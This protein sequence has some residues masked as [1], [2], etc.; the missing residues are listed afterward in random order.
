VI[1]PFVFR[2]KYV[3]ISIIIV[4][5]LFGEYLTNTLAFEILQRKSE[6]SYQCPGTMWMEVGI[7]ALQVSRLLLC[8]LTSERF[9]ECLR[10]QI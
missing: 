10:V 3:S 8:D 5:Y 9:E 4:F 2:Q 1:Q 6:V 7:V